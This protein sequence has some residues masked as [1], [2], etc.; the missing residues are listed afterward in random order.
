MKKLLTALIIAA[1][2]FS[3]S[4]CAD[5]NPYPDW[6]WLNNSWVYVGTENPSPSPPPV[7]PYIR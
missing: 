5:E 3:G 6:I 1:A 7:P 2:L 4:I